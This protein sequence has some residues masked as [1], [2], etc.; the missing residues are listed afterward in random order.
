MTK[1]SN[2]PSL[3]PKSWKSLST[4]KL[5][6]WRKALEWSMAESVILAELMTELDQLKT[7]SDNP[8]YK[9]GSLK[10][11]GEKWPNF[12]TLNCDLTK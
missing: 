12:L 5:N 4:L 3:Q 7:E 9:D 10:Y 2:S 11:M 1:D 8:L 6:V